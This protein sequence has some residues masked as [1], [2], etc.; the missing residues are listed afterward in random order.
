[1]LSTSNCLWFGVIG[2]KQPYMC[3]CYLKHLNLWNAEPAIILKCL[4]YAMNNRPK[5]NPLDWIVEKYVAWKGFLVKALIYFTAVLQNFSNSLGL[6]SQYLF[7][8][9]HDNG[10]TPNLLS[11]KK[12]PF[13]VCF[14]YFGCCTDARRK[15]G[16]NWLTV[17]NIIKAIVQL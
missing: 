1:M 7:H 2:Q 4:K 12:Q 16:F 8:I 3:P 11:T 10:D 17:T 9:L 13:G 15:Q 14:E 5:G 6:Y